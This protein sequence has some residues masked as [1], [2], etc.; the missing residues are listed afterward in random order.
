VTTIDAA[1]G[2]EILKHIGRQQQ[3]GQPQPPAPR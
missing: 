2:N 3:F 1:R